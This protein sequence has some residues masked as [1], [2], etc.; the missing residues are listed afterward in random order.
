MFVL[1]RVEATTDMFLLLYSF[2]KVIHRALLSKIMSF[3][4]VIDST[5]FNFESAL[6]PFTLKKWWEKCKKFF[7]KVMSNY[8]RKVYVLYPSKELAD[9]SR[10]VLKVWGI[11]SQVAAQVSSVVTPSV[12]CEKLPHLLG[13][14]AHSMAMKVEVGTNQRC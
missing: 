12:L 7:D 13:E 5:A 1:R 11:K 4:L 9:M 10:R 8:L 6:E 2:V 14:L 3:D